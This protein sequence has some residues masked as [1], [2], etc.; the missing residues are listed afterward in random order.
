MGRY[1]SIACL[2]ECAC[3]LGLQRISGKF[4]FE[5]ETY[6]EV[7]YVLRAEKTA[8]YEFGER[9]FDGRDGP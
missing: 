4:R 9:V 8:N 2:A 7:C 6:Q 1:P 5:V 3:S